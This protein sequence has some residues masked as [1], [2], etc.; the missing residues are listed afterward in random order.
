M[1]KFSCSSVQGENVLTLYN[2]E[3]LI[4]GEESV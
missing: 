2:Q 4:F 1:C 3:L